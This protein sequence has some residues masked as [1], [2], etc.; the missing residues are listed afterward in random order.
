MSAKSSSF[1]Q[2]VFSIENSLSILIMLKMVAGATGN[3]IAQNNNQTDL[4]DLVPTDLSNP[5]HSRRSGFT[6]GQR[7]HN[8]WEIC[9][10]L[11]CNKITKTSIQISRQ[12]RN[13]IFS[14][15][16]HQ[17]MVYLTSIVSSSKN[18]PYKSQKCKKLTLDSHIQTYQILTNNDEVCIPSISSIL[19]AL[20][21]EFFSLCIP[22]LQKN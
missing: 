1:E 18:K 2:L 5:D 21:A 19:I 8:R 16:S 4:L 6:F 20:S 15:F 10:Y 12:N 14:N 13:G 22:F 3:V 7:N 9:D 11:C 17:I